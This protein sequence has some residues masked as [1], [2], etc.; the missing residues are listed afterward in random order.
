M[1]NKKIKAQLHCR[2]NPRAKALP[3]STVQP[4]GGNKTKGNKFGEVNILEQCFEGMRE[5]LKWIVVIL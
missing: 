3:Q 5:N 4:V 1:R 2:E